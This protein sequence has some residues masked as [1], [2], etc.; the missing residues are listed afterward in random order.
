MTDVQ[1]QKAT[2]LANI[3]QATGHSIAHFATEVESAGLERHGQIVAHLKSTHG[4][5]HGNANALAHAVR[6]RL[7]GGPP[8]ADD[9]LGAQYAGAKE[10]L[11]PIHDAVVAQARAL[12]DDV[13]VVVQK[14]GVSLRRAKQFA[15]VQAPSAKRVQLSL[16]LDA[17]P[18]GGRVVEAG[19][20]CTHRADLTSIDD[21][22]HE[23]AGWLAAAYERAG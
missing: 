23:V 1:A 22:D 8:A 21:V 15:L 9:L 16:N 18:P 11:R 12:G 14:T 2:Q 5:T 13:E 20:M 4:L 3:E 7:A 19:G 6:E 10:A 17:T